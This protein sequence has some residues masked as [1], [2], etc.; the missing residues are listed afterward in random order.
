M[1]SVVS[2]WPGV[3]IDTAHVSDSLSR[4]HPC[5]RHVKTRS[6]RRRITSLRQM[7]NGFQLIRPCTSL[8]GPP[9]TSAMEHAYRNMFLCL[10][11]T[12]V[13]HGDGFM[14]YKRTH[15]S[16]EQQDKGTRMD[17]GTTPATS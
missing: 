7:N 17:V 15:A 13:F 5:S 8:P 2:P 10:M 14:A 12:T 16:K 1:S 4:A 9:N 6:G 3:D 11:K